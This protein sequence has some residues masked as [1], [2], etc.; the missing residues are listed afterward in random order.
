MTSSLTI[1][2][3]RR[4]LLKSTPRKESVFYGV[5]FN[6]ADALEPIKV[7]AYQKIVGNSLYSCPLLRTLNELTKKP[8]RVE[9]S[10]V[11]L[12]ELIEIISSLLDEY[13]NVL[14]KGMKLIKY[15]L[16]KVVAN[17]GISNQILH[18]IKELIK[19]D[20]DIVT[21]LAKPLAKEMVNKIKVHNLIDLFIALEMLPLM[22]YPSSHITNEIG[23]DI[24]SMFRDVIAFVRQNSLNNLGNKLTYLR[25]LALQ[26]FIGAELIRNNFRVKS[27]LKVCIKDLVRTW[28]KLDEA[29]RLISAGFSNT[30]QFR[31]PRVLPLINDFKAMYLLPLDYDIKTFL[32]TLRGSPE[33]VRFCISPTKKTR[34]EVLNE[35]SELIY[36]GSSGRNIIELYLPYEQSEYFIIRLSTSI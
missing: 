23:L 18:Y 15:Y 28:S 21:S 3:T 17:Q 29:S 24:V 16:D 35:F 5:N 36:E 1:H 7:T 30:I 33:R 10:K 6:I 13:S 34:V 19:R 22:A 11:T 31:P 26:T 20:K 32:V 4:N 12:I 9:W 14:D 25:S 8:S 27:D 2:H